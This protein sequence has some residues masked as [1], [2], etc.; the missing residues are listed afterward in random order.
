VLAKIAAL[1][2]IIVFIQRRPQGMFRLEG[3]GAGI[4]D[5]P[6]SST[7][8]RLYGANGWA[9]LG[10]VAGV[11]FVAFPLLNLV[12]PPPAIPRLG[13]LGHAHRQDH[14][15]AIV[16]LAMD[17]IWATRDSS[18]GTACSRA[19]RLRFGMYSCARSG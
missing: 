13:V 4:L 14:V 10:A 15:Y 6:I 5:G 19:R 18:W 8:S 17:L 11:L 2:F 1:V 16:A 9:A 3:P 12:V 7:F